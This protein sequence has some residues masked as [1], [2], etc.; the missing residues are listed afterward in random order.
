MSIQAVVVLTAL[1]AA[2]VTTMKLVRA[3]G[4]RS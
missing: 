3:P 2:R 1:A 4:V